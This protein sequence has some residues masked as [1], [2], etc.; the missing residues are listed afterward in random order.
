MTLPW[1]Q[2]CHHNTTMGT[3][4]PP[5]HHHGNG[6]VTMA[7][8]LEATLQQLCTTGPRHDKLPSGTTY[9]SDTRNDTMPSCSIYTID[10]RHDTS[11]PWQSQ[12]DYCT[13]EI[14]K[15]TI[16]FSVS[17]QIRACRAEDRLRIQLYRW[18]LFPD[19]ELLQTCQLPFILYLFLFFTGWVIYM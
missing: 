16:P 4:M 15:Y 2:K 1:E 9:I 17:H 7:Y 11:W 13:S 6:N 3:E 5:W 8:L 10:S 18:R 19:Y 12:F 14:S